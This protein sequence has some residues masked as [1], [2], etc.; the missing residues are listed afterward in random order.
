MQP[1]IC[2]NS[3]VALADKLK[4]FIQKHGMIK[5]L[6]RIEQGDDQIVLLVSAD[7]DLTPETAEVF[8]SGYK[9]ALEGS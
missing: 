4:G 5:S 9:F 2:K 8:W 1:I 6:V 7:S 3:A